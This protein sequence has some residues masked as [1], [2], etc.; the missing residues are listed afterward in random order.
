MSPQ[1]DFQTYRPITGCQRSL[2]FRFF[3][4]SDHFQAWSPKLAKVQGGPQGWLRWPNQS[5]LSH[6]PTWY[7]K[8]GH[9]LI[10]IPIK[11]ENWPPDLSYGSIILKIVLWAH[12]TITHAVLSQST[13]ILK[14][15]YSGTPT[16]HLRLTHLLFAGGIDETSV[17]LRGDDR[18]GNQ[19]IRREQVEALPDLRLDQSK[20]SLLSGTVM[21]FHSFDSF[22]TNHDFALSLF[23]SF[24]S[25]RAS[26]FQTKHSK[27]WQNSIRH[28]LSLNECFVK[29]EFFYHWFFCCSSLQLMKI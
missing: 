15:T 18:D 12:F 21:P 17:Q 16:G 9:F 3:F 2:F 26:N 20:V 7:S 14:T 8:S 24:H 6:F 19:W 28:N 11:K 13:N 27:G 22:P 10:E 1:N 5:Y 29:V 23:Q 25:K 4:H